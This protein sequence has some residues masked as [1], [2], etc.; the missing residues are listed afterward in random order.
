[1]NTNRKK[2][3]KKRDHEKS[4]EP[5][6]WAL[7]SCRRKSH[8]ANT[9]MKTGEEKGGHMT[10]ATSIILKQAKVTNEIFEEEVGAKNQSE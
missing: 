8:F 3:R 10:I 5:S 7:P 6:R 1:M 2:K 9:K 4:V